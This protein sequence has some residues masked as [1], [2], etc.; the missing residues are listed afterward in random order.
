MISPDWA[1]KRLF[2]LWFISPKHPEPMREKRW[3]ESA[4][5]ISIPHQHGPIATYRWGTGNERIFLLHGWSGRGPQMGAFVQPL[6]DKGYQ[7]IT[8]DAPGHGRTPGKSSSIFKMA[9]AL[10]AVVDEAG[11]P[12]AVIAHSFGSMLLAYALRATDL[13]VDKAVC[14]SSPTTMQYLVDRFCQTLH[15]NETTRQ[16]FIREIENSY[17][18]TIWENMSA[19]KNIQDINIP[20]L[21]IHDRDDHDV[22]AYL[23]KQLSD[24]WQGSRY[25]ETRGLGHRRILRNQDIVNTVVEFID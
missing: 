6:V 15:I 13:Q 20:A 3:R 18:K 17:G 12:K 24:A 21:I 9:E 1:G 4:E 22:P 23:G 2:N 25:L 11:I 16:S 5:L 7:V 19:D 14:I 8:F 10:Q